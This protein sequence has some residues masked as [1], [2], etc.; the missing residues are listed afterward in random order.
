MG[1]DFVAVDIWRFRAPGTEAVASAPEK[2]ESYGLR[3][4]ALFLG[5]KLGAKGTGSG[6]KPGHGVKNRLL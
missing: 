2:R 5:P 1:Q 6:F 4:P 3:W